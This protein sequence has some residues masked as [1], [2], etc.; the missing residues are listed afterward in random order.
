MDELKI[1]RRKRPSIEELQEH[2]AELERQNRLLRRRLEEDCRNAESEQVEKI[3]ASETM[4]IAELIINN[5]PAIL[6]R[7][8]SSTDPKKRKMVYVSPNISQFGYRAEDF[9]EGRIMYRDILYSG[10]LDRMT[11]EIQ[12][13]AD[14]NTKEYTQ[15]YRI[16]TRGGS[17]RW[18]EDRTSVVEDPETGVRYNQGIVIDIHRRKEAEERL[19]KSEEKYRRIVETTAEGFLLLDEDMNI[20]DVNDAFCR[21]IGTSRSDL[22]GRALFEIVTEE[23]RPSWFS[24][25]QEPS[26]N[27]ILQFEG[28]LRTR[29]GRL[30]PALIHGSVLLDDNGAIIGNMA[31]V[32]DMTEQ[33][34]ALT[35]AAEVQRSL[36]PRKSPQVVGLDV[37]GR[38][39]SCDGIGGDYF[40]FLQ[41]DGTA[42]GPFTVVVG[43]ITGHGVDSAL[44]MTTAR[45]FLRM[46]ASHDAVLPEL[47]QGPVSHRVGARR[48]RS[49][50]AV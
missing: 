40:D 8:L 29:G 15:V 5:S 46:R 27:D 17:V 24:G 21:I 18:V 19:R 31:F 1:S 12:A 13:F 23:S 7:R 10:D 45:A 50:M 6:F 34:K 11:K 4:K 43:D 38:N 35:L 20:R 44:L 30:V 37:A 26:S 25:R 22:F 47:Q 41:N 39:I 9:L 16:V 36:L 32:T 49:R 2:L 3:K 33:K 28:N 42:E 14:R 48:P